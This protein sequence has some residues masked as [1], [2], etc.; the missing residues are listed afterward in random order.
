MDFSEN[1]GKRTAR[2]IMAISLPRLPV[3][4]LQ[5]KPTS[6]AQSKVPLVIAAKI[7]NA[8]RIYALDTRAA[9]C[10]LYAGQALANARAMFEPLDVVEADPAADSKLLEQI[11]EWCSRFT[12]FVALDPPHALFLDVT[13]VTHLFGGEQS[14]LAMVAEALRKQGFTVA[15]AM[16][17]TSVAARAL[18]RYA[19]GIIAAPGEEA[20]TI[21][22]LP[23]TALGCD[24]HTAHALKRA[25]LKTIGHLLPRNRSELAARFGKAFVF[26][27]ECAL[28]HSENPISPRTALPD[29]MAEHRFA[30]PVIA[31]AV[32]FE[33]LRSLALSIAHILEERGQGARKLEA[34]FFRADGGTRRIAVEAGTPTRDAALIE[35]LFRLKL[36]SLAAPLDPGFGFDLIRLEATLAQRADAQS[37]SFD[38][39]NAEGEIAQLIDTLSTRFGRQ[40]VLRFLP[41][42]THIPESASVAIPAQQPMPEK[43]VWRLKRGAD[44]GP[45]RPLRLF[46]KP[47]P[48]EVMA[49]VPDG[50]PLRFRWRRMQH[51]AVSAEGPERIAMEWWRHDALMPTRDYFR[52][53]DSEGRRFWLFRDGP[54][55]GGTP[56]PSWYVHGLFA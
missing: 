8:M 48:I 16:A 13:G 45:R 50:P 46:A 4:R 24:S 20:K 36:E 42:D 28:G 10:G 47:E 27:L 23:V 3:D 34:V 39:S 37:T 17:G 1:P 32:I 25:G 49:E 21:A 55:Q 14:M 2:R 38:D 51:I 33:T 15:L 40:R 18:S 12:P 31:D 22:P 29:Y 19:P 53:Q 11:T 54:Y 35:R 52:V 9:R 43:P 7:D 30:E 44:E 5:R 6:A 41:Q 26:L 56:S